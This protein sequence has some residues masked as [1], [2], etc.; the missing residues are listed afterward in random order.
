[1]T[2]AGTSTDES[3]HLRCVAE[4]VA[5]QSADHLMRAFR[6]P[7]SVE[8]KGGPYDLVTEHDLA[9]E[10]IIR[11]GVTR[12][13]PDSVVLGEEGG[14]SGTGRVTWHVDPIDGTVNFSH[15]LAFWCISIAAVV[16]DVVV[17]GVIAAPALGEVYA[18]DLTGVTV[19]GVPA[20]PR[21]VEREIDSLV[22]STFPRDLDLESNGDDALTASGR[23]IRSYGA[24]R[25]LGS[26]ALG[27]AH[28]ATGRADATFDLHTNSWDVAA[29]AFMVRLGG[30]RYLGC[31]NGVVDEEPRTSYRRPAY[32]ATAAHLEHPTLRSVVTDLT[33]G[34]QLPAEQGTHQW[35]QAPS[36]SA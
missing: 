14:L 30:G 1:M 4:E 11:E 10:A 28:V 23:I 8:H 36:A 21:R 7:M 15:G 19:N 13:V 25:T 29:G 32:W 9:S 27:L 34:R 35:R 3:R 6:R 12:A 16:D 22:I 5:A 26:G 31:E 2:D 20:G 24:S 18:A 33:A 17:A